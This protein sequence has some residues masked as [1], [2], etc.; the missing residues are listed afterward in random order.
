MLHQK[1]NYSE[2]TL[3]KKLWTSQQQQSGE[4][5]SNFGTGGRNL[6]CARLNGPAFGVKRDAAHSGGYGRLEASQANKVLFQGGA[7]KGSLS[8]DSHLH[9]TSTVG[10]PKIQKGL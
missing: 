7:L 5:T 3:G 9:I 10:S 8:S 2:K 6:Y 4:G 1:L